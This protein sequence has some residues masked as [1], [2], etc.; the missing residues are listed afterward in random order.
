MIT[1]GDI[2]DEL[3]V[4]SDYLVDGGFSGAALALRALVGLPVELPELKMVVGLV[5]QDVRTLAFLRIAWLMRHEMDDLHIASSDSVNLGYT[6]HGPHAAKEAEGLVV[7]ADRW[8]RMEE[9]V[10]SNIQQRDALQAQLDALLPPTPDV[11]GN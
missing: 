10:A 6:M 8:R 7:S 5:P 11:E 3:A 9:S 1:A 2:H 4:A